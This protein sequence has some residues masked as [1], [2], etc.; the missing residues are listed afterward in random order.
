MMQWY[1]DHAQM[2]LERRMSDYADRILG[3]GYGC[4]DIKY[5]YLKNRWGYWNP[6]GS[7]T[8]NIELIKTPIACVDY[9][10]IHELCHFTHPNHDKAFYKL[11]RNI[12]PDW[13]ERKEKLER[14]GVR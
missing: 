14:F 4:I 7:L 12:I 13:S 6:D 8:F 10:I 9:V 5:K 3:L 2:I 11:M 1:A